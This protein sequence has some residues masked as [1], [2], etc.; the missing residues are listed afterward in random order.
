MRKRM[1]RKVWAKTTKAE[2]SQKDK[3]YW[4]TKTPEQRLEMLA[5][6]QKQYIEMFYDGLE[7]RFERVYRFVKRKRR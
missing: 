6:L 2:A 5:L 4:R 7:P 1:N 3:A